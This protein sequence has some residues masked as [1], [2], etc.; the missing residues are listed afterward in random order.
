MSLETDLMEVERGLWA[1]DPDLY[2]DSLTEQAMLVFPKTG[3]ITRNFAVKAI[4]KEVAKNRHWADVYFE[5]VRAQEIADNVAALTY[6]VTARWND[7]KDPSVAIASSIYV[8]RGDAWKL[9]LHQQ[10]QLPLA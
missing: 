6:K 9:A 4:R 2:R 7:E 1:N 10:G 8:R 3:V 5:D